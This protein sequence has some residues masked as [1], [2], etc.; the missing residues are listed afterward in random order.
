MANA[1][2]H[3]IIRKLVVGFGN[4]FDNIK[5][6]RYN[7]DGTEQERMIVPIAYESKELYVQ[8]L[9]GDPNLDKKVQMTLPRM[10]FEM[11]GLNYDTARKQNTN[12][13][14]FVQT[15][16]GVIAQYNPV[17]YNFD[18]DLNIYVRN[19]EDGAQI[20]EHILSYFTPDYTIKLNMIPEMGIVKEVPIIL[21]RTSHEI[22]YEGDRD[23]STRMII[24]NLQF[25]VKGFIFGSTST[26]GLI[27]TSITNILS[28]ITPQ[29]V[30]V[31]NLATPGFGNFK[32]GE[33]IYQGV[34]LNTSTATAKVVGWVNGKLSVQNVSGNFVTG[35]PIYGAA[36]KA[37]YVFNSYN[38]ASKEIPSQYVQIVS[39]PNPAS[40]NADS[41]YTYMTTI[42]EMGGPSVVIGDQN[43]NIVYAPSPGSW[44]VPPLIITDILDLQ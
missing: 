17:P 8:R 4:L 34:S 2:Y 28:Q 39:E 43:N 38:S 20:I 7:P 21:N 3:R 11:T 22:S 31:F 37:H 13:K 18:F 36:S 35:Q 40:A 25:T 19:Q 6:V 33:M 29:T 41:D 9:Q 16:N 14:N 10:S 1:Q 23:S 12:W 24:W 27:K 32:V 44:R 42:T 15:D 5:L 30:M 26:T